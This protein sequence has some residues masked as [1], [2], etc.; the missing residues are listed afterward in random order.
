MPLHCESGSERFEPL[1]S[2]IVPRHLHG[3]PVPEAGAATVPGPG[4]GAGAGAGASASADGLARSCRPRRA[5]PVLRAAGRIG[6]A[7]E[8]A[9]EWERCGSC[10]HICK[11]VWAKRPHRGEK[12]K[13]QK[14]RLLICAQRS[15]RVPHNEPFHR[16]SIYSLYAP[17]AL[18]PR[19]CTHRMLIAQRPLRSAHRHPHTGHPRGHSV[20]GLPPRRQTD[21]PDLGR[22]V[23]AAWP[24]RRPSPR[25]P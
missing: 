20:R 22:R 11:V 8:G 2:T 3:R 9:I 10:V 18:Q 4:A 13:T 19:P 25:P 7:A 5:R 6:G 21:A 24:A 12:P 14:L 17:T 15:L 23:G 16:S 1:S